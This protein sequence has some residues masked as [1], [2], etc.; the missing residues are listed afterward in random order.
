MLSSLFAEY[1]IVIICSNEDGD[2]AHMVSKLQIYNRQFSGTMKPVADFV[3][4]F[5]S[6]FINWPKEAHR[7][8]LGKAIVASMVDAEE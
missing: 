7:K 3:K 1:K 2:K 5:R 4:Y 8:S 6:K